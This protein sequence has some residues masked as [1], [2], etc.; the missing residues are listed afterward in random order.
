MDICIIRPYVYFEISVYDF[1]LNFF[2]NAVNFKIVLQCILLVKSTN[3][4]G[5]FINI[6]HFCCA[7]VERLRDISSS[8]SSHKL[9]SV[10]SH[11]RFPADL[12][13]RF[14]IQLDGSMSR[15]NHIIRS[16]SC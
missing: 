8:A 2:D 14:P 6:L 13:V 3:R 9:L 1:I 16:F 4:V 10:H 5:S 7:P 12:K 11:S 15:M